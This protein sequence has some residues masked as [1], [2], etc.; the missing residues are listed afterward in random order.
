MKITCDV[1]VIGGGPAGATA[2]RLLAQKNLSVVLAQKDLA[3]EK[4]CGGALPLKAFAEFGLD[5]RF[6]RQ[7]VDALA[8]TAPSGYRTGAAL[9]DT[10]LAVVDRRA[11]DAHLR[12]LAEADGVRVVEGKCRMTGETSAE[13]VMGRERVAVEAAYVVAADGVNS[14]TRKQLTGTRPRRVLSLYAKVPQTLEEGCAFRFGKAVAPGHYAWAF[15]HG[16]GTHIGV[17][18]D[19]EKAIFSHFDAFCRELG[20]TRPPKANGFYIPRWRD[21][22][23]RRGN[24][25]FVGDA[26]GQV[27]PFTYEGIYYAMRSAVCA[28]EAIAGGDLDRYERLW[29]AH[30]RRRFRAMALLQRLLLHFDRGAEKLVRLQENAAV[31]AAA[32]RFWSGKS[33][34]SSP[35]RTFVKALKL[36]LRRSDR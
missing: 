27:S 36:L 31:H 22:L 16:E 12:V 11:F 33:M 18:A 1:L 5:E 20:L 7:R 19:D 24:V 23:Y 26:A 13:I 34:P 4:P 15:V 35:L 17:I 10:P 8:L 3:Y 25:L 28:A 32:L 6:V 30:L 21:D 14:S 29:R 9:G 2:A